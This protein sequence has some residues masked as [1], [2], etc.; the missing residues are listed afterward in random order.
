MARPD[1]VAGSR[2]LSVLAIL[3]GLA[4]LAAALLWWGWFYRLIGLGPAFPCLY[5]GGDTC[6]FI[7][8]VAA[9]AGRVA[10]SPAVFRLGA[11]ALAGG[12]VARL[13]VAMLR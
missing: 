4:L 6:G 7:R 3:G 1:I 9:E 10:Y 12:S 8:H 5:G 2:R 13:A 11:V